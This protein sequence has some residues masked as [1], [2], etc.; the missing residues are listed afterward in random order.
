MSD[1]YNAPLQTYVAST[2]AKF[3]HDMP[4]KDRN[5][6]D[7]SSDFEPRRMLYWEAIVLSSVPAFC[8]AIITLL[9]LICRCTFKCCRVMLVCCNCVKKT[10]QKYRPNPRKAIISF[11]VVGTIVVG[12]V[13]YGFIANSQVSTGVKEVQGALTDMQ[14]MKDDN[15]LKVKSISTDMGDLIATTTSLRDAITQACQDNS[16]PV[17]TDIQNTLN[18]ITDA[19]DSGKS[20]IDD[21]IDSFDTKYS[22][23]DIN[24]KIT[25]YDGYRFNIQVA[26][27]GVLLLPYIM[28]AISI[29]FNLK[30]L[31]WN[32]TWVS[33]I[34]A[35]LGWLLTGL[36][37]AVSLTVSDVCIDPTTNLIDE[38]RQ[39]ENGTE[40]INFI[41]Y[42]LVCKDKLNPLQDEIDAAT[43]ALN[44]TTG[45]LNDL[46]A[47][48]SEA[49]DNG[50]INT[51]QNSSI[52][53]DVINMKTSTV[54][55]IDT[56]LDLISSIFK[57]NRIH[58]NY[59]STIDGICNPTLDGWFSLMIIQGGMA[60]LMWVAI[61]SAIKL[62]DYLTAKHLASEPVNLKG[63]LTG[64]ILVDDDPYLK[65]DPN[66]NATL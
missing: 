15:I 31:V 4:R 20:E 46:S 8:L 32:V 10:E 60:F 5:F 25:K 42:F 27:F 28:V 2:I 58:N 38:A 29:L 48:V 54:S 43:N 11:L 64:A 34:A 16:Q 18:S 36:E 7:V 26:V 35:F 19:L 56:V 53:S 39:L 9:F 45:F 59:I 65:A 3:L 24:K 57:C 1:P 63:L 40:F 51:S 13:I 6:D 50:V 30:W 17:P 23:D 14:D 12:G 52:Q 21:N 41:E 66:V 33:V 44:D 49:V 47:Y 61:Y 55:I 22:I 62:Y 37:T